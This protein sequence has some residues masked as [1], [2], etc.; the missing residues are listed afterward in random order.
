MAWLDTG[1]HDSL[2]EAGQFIQV[3]EKRQ[4]LKIACPEEVA[5]RQG[6]I[7]SSQLETLAKPLI[8]SGYGKYLMHLINDSIQSKLGTNYV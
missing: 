4:G 7:T 5:W 3:L 6:W 8:K 2:I 1:T